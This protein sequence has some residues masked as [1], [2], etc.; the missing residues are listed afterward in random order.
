[1]PTLIVHGDSDAI[2]PFEVSG[3]RSHE[4]ID[5]SSLVL[6][7]GGPHGLTPPTPSSSTARCSTS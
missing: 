6:I 1:V 4:A 7:E 2:V 3:K 5:G